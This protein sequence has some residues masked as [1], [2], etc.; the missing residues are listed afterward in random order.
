MCGAKLEIVF[1]V[2]C[3]KLIQYSET[4]NFV[5]NVFVWRL[6]ERLESEEVVLLV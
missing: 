1:G 5:I 6:H 4:I 3:C 2:Y